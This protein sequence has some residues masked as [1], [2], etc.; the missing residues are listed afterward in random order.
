M[1]FL[2]FFWEDEKLGSRVAGWGNGKVEM[3]ERWKG[4]RVARWGN[5]N[6]GKRE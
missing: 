3:V 4:N 6:V 5:G 2:I 1:E